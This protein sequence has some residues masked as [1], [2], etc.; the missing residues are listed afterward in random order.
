[1]EDPGF[2]MQIPIEIRNLFNL[3][4]SGLAGKGSDGVTAT[5]L[6][7][8]QFSAKSAGGDFSSVSE[9]IELQHRRRWEGNYMT[10]GHCMAGQSALFPRTYREL[11][12]RNLT[13]QAV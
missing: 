13:V 7:L 10:W 5:V 12:V 2:L 11:Q 1:M 4:K 8:I 6:Q 3:T 9:L